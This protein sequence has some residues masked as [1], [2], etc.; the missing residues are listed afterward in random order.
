MGVA[1][2]GN[3]FAWFEVG[4]TDLLRN[5]GVTYRDLEAGGIRLPVIEAQARFLR[6][7]RYDDVLDIH[8]RLASLGGVRIAF[9]YEVQ[10]RGSRRSAGHGLDGPRRRRRGRTSPAPARGDPEA[11]VVKVVV[12]G[13]A[14]FIGSQ[15]VE[16][17]LGEGHEVVGIDAFVD[18]YPREAKEKNLAPAREHAS[19][20][21]VEGRLQ[22][23][24]LEPL[25]DGAAQVYHL[26]AQ[27]GVRAS[28][29][30]DFAVY[31][32]HNVLATQ[33]LL[34][35]AVA[36]GLG[37]LVYASSSSVYGDSAA[38][39][40]RE[41][42][43]CRPVS[44]Y[45]VTKLAAEHLVHLYGKNHGLA[46]V[47]LRYFTVYGPRQRPD[48]A[49]HRFLKATRDGA[50][51]HVFGDGSQT[52]DFTFVDDI[53]SATRAAADTGRPG[54]VYNVGGGE[55]IALERRARAHRRGHGTAAAGHSGRR[56]ERGHE[57][58]VGRHHRGAA[59]SRL[60]FVG[61]A[62]AGARARMGMDAGGAMR[63]ARGVRSAPPRPLGVR[64]RVG[65]PGGHRHAREQL[66][67]GDLGGGPEGRREEAVDCRAAI[68]QADRRR[69]PPEPVRP[70]RPPR[71][72]A[73]AT[74]AREAPRT[75]YSRSRNTA[76][77]SPS[78]PLIRRA[79]TPS[80]GSARPTTPRRTAPTA[81]RRRRT[82]PSPSTSTF[83]RSTL[84][85]PGRGGP[86]PDLC[87]PPDAWGAPSSSPGTSTSGPARPTG[88]RSAATKGS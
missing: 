65:R 86:G 49:F 62:A 70:R 88:P 73:T 52:R 66:R 59:R 22:E 21:F 51:I 36:R 19:F 54:H 37:R 1:Y 5:L 58:H 41:D 61:R 40:L 23:M 87:L 17:L 67:P 48:M 63:R 34:E 4:R 18:Y 74:S 20:R 25:L 42:S 16:R 50:P 72:G 69:L 55:R 68:L 8:T 9:E 80:S 10:A 60:P 2:H 64:M 3:Y 53:V 44:P 46:A 85:P 81:T 45:G 13:A 75:R 43:P 78:T 24:D 76:I 11:P 31:T 29:G 32:D 57:G 30:R 56:P 71:P 35:A 82:T 12:T 28:W 26:A 15:L 39:P 84:P 7:A 14:G 77:S 38:L 83:S 79:T 33:R 6:P 47:S 27:A